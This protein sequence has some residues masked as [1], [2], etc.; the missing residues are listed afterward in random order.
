MHCLEHTL[1]VLIL[2]GKKVVLKKKMILKKNQKL[3]KILLIG[4]KI[5]LLL[6]MKI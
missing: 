1:K 3:I 4:L 6:E 2:N 5:T